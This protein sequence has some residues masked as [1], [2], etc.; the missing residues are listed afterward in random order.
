MPIHLVGDIRIGERNSITVFSGA[1]YELHPISIDRGEY[2]NNYLDLFYDFYGSLDWYD[3]TTIDNSI[4]ITPKKK[5][6]EAIPFSIKFVEHV[7]QTY[8]SVNIG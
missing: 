7:G 8:F 6:D 3:V 4:L 2:E 1:E 5:F